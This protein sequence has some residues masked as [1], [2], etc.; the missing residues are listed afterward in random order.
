M[1]PL[2][3]FLLAAAAFAQTG[4]AI[5]GS[6]V[7]VAGDVVANAPIQATNTATKTLYTATSSEKGIYTIAQLPAG[8]YDVSVAVPGFNAYS[9][10]GVAVAAG[11][12]VRFNIRLIDFQ[13]NTLGDG[14][15]FRISQLTPHPTPSGPTPRTQDGKPDLSGVW[16]A[17]RTV[18]P[19]KPEPLP[20][21][22]ALQRERAAN[23]SKDAPGARCLPRG[24]TNAGALF[25]YQLVQT[26]ALLVM[27]FEDDT[28]SHR[29]VYLDGR[30]HPKEPNPNW[31]GHSI[32]HWE[33]DTLVVD[34]VGFNDESWL[35]NTGYPHT[36]MMRITER[37]H[38][39]DLGHLEIELTIEDP[40]AYSKPWVMKRVA[41]LDTKD[42]IGEYVCIDRDA[43]HMVGK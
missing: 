33:G 37:L 12:T 27:I 43:P 38:R 23:N 16:Y 22:D 14:R 32:G 2:I 20:W 10:Q 24:L 19:G 15:D 4:G 36:E 26:P 18:D 40:G 13:L 3:V 39:A 21:A 17:Q 28:P 34:T 11:Q 25:P 6:V 1:G 30:G 7:D 5:T 42:E 41:D 35:V 9:Q 8:T 29:L 31:M